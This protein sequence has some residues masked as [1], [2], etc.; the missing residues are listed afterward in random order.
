MKRVLLLSIAIVCLSFISK[1]QETV[2]FS[3]DQTTSLFSR[4]DIISWGMGDAANNYVNFGTEAEP[5]FTEVADNPVKTG[6]NTSDKALHMYSLQGHSWWPDFL[7][8]TLTDPITITESNRYLHIY[9]YRENLN[10]GFTVY[11]SANGDWVEDPEKGTRRF[12][13]DLTTA[14]VWEDVVVDLQWFIDNSTPL[15]AVNFLVDRNWGGETEAATNYYWDEIVLSDS[16][17]PRGI[18][19]YTA[20]KIEID[21]GNEDSYNTWVK[22]LDLQNSENSYEIVDNPFTDQT[23]AAPFN[24]IMKFN[25]SENASWWQ[26]GPRF[27]LT[28][29]LPVENVGSAAYFHAFINIPDMEAGVDYYVVQLCVKDFSGNEI[30]SEDILKYWSDDAG[31]WVDMVMDVTSIG[32][33]SEVQVRFDVRRDADDNHINSPAGVFYLDDLVVNDSEEQ[34]EMEGSSIAKNLGETNIKVYPANKQLIVEGNAASVEVYNLMGSFVGK[35]AGNTTKTIIPVS[36][37]GIYL[38]KAIKADHSV[39]VSKVV[40]K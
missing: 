17:L 9:H 19:L 31:Y 10:K 36:Q 6:L 21:L 20:D 29:T 1:A 11:L 40:I 34:R 39:S 5:A 4:M 12:D 38:V 37:N 24:T 25:K 8:M 33:V 35:Y 18:N 32:Y 28:G 3:G 2:L 26:G 15:E 14:G 16:N 30:S 7:T 23:T 22:T 13:M 27:L